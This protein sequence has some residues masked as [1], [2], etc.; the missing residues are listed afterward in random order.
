MH[1]MATNLSVWLA[2]VA[3]EATEALMYEQRI[4]DWEALQNYP[5]Q[6]NRSG[7]ASVQE[8]SVAEID[9]GDVFGTFCYRILD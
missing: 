6:S 2:T 3:G 7:D 8:G 1:I 9:K 4:S 5:S